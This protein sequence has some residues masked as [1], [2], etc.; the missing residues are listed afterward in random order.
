MW[1]YSASSSSLGMDLQQQDGLLLWNTQSIG[2]SVMHEPTP[3]CT[4][5]Y[6]ALVDVCAAG[7]T[8]DD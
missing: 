5:R 3:L 4:A 6:C 7:R 1:H 2:A 8:K